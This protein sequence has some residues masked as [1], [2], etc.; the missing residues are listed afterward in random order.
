M[1]G[2]LKRAQVYVSVMGGE[3]E[4][5]ETMAALGRASGFVRRELASRLDLRYAPQIEF[6]QDLTLESASRLE[7]LLDQIHE[8]TLEGNEP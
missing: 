7:A 1:S 6:T 5:Q 2:D 8:R 4:T 3:E